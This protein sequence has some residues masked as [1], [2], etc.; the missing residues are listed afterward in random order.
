M[1]QLRVGF[2]SIYAWRPHVEHMMFLARLVQQ[3]GHAASFLACDADLPACYTRELRDVR[4]DWMECLMCRAGGV[5]SYTGRNVTSIGS[6]AGA[7][8]AEAL[9]RGSEWAASSASTL[10]RFESPADYASPEFAQLRERLAPTA[11]MAYEAA[12]AWIRREGLD[13]ICLFNGRMDATRGIFEAARAA[14]VRVVTFER[15]WFGD[16]IQ[17]LPDEHCLG[18]ES[19]HAMVARWSTVP[20]SE[21]QARKAAAFVA[22]RLTRTNLS[23][24]RAYNVDARETG[25]PV[26]GGRRRILV[27]PSSLNE[28]WSMPGWASPWGGAAAGFDAVIAHLGLQPQDLVLRC[29]PNWSERIGK[30]DGRLPEAHYTE[31]AR[32]RGIH[33]IASA[34]KAST[35]SLIAQCDAVLLASGSAALEAAALG[36]QVI[37]I[38]PS[39]YQEAGF[40]TDASTPEAL[41]RLVLDVDLPRQHRAAAQDRLRRGTLRFLYTVAYRLP[42]YV[43]HVKAIS[44]TSYRYVPGADPQRLVDLLRTGQLQADDAFASPDATGEDRVAALLQA[45]EWEALRQ[46]PADASAASDRVRRRW[47]LQ[48]VDFIREKM[49]VGDR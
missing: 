6:L 28:V 25:W 16:G 19:W 10:G 17:L 48:P 40:R 38:G 18:L 21:V 46:P 32:A 35:M 8:D 39:H 23:E 44:T 20:L 37:A 5:R 26:A 47:F 36:K 14:G 27:L 2:A 13:A 24:W 9:A 43:Q 12:S 41:A 33:A 49:P 7:P 45:G 4:P 22:A 15:T 11:A 1:T 34:D 30:R 29:H 42:Q 31:W 3:A